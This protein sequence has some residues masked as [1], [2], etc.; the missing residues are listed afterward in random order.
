MMFLCAVQHRKGV[1]STL[2][3]NGARERSKTII[4]RGARQGSLPRTAT[5]IHSLLYLTLSFPPHLTVRYDHHRGY[6][7]D[8]YHKY[9]PA[10]VSIECCIVLNG[11]LAAEL[12]FHGTRRK[13]AF[14][15]CTEASGQDTTL[16]SSSQVNRK[17]EYTLIKHQTRWDRRR[18][19]T[20]SFKLLG[21]HTGHRTRCAHSPG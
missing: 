18:V 7:Q 6:I 3:K 21:E 15:A 17:H 5:T 4:V 9:S 12:P 2:V 19:C 1:R 20:I 8:I 13:P 11:N 14:T 10:G 16:R